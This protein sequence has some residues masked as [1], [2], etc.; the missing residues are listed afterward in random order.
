MFF[1]IIVV[2]LIFLGIYLYLSGLSYEIKIQTGT[3]PFETIYIGYKFYKGAYCD[4]YKAFKELNSIE[5]LSDK[6]AIGIFYDDHKK[7][8]FKIIKN[9]VF[10]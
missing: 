1:L 3:P 5:N 8:S 4:V 2:V 7:V 9:Q 6:N 10:F